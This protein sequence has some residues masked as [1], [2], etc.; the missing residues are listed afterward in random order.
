MREETKRWLEYAAEN[1]Q[2]SRICL[3]SGLFNA[4]L[5]NAQQSVEKNFKAIFLDFALKL[6]RTHNIEKLT[7][8]LKQKGIMVNISTEDQ[9]LLDSIYTPSK[10]PLSSSLPDFEPD[11]DICHRC[12]TIAEG[13]GRSVNQIIIDKH[14]GK[15]QKT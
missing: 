6:I 12:I 13:V 3:K 4:C 8:E 7:S 5:Q 2:V 10:Y 1:L 15:N 11:S 9:E 14:N